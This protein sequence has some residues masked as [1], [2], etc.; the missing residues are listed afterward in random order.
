MQI[1]CEFCGKGFIPERKW[2]RFCTTPCRVRDWN[3]RHPRLTVAKGFHVHI[4][5]DEPA[6]NPATVK[7]K[8]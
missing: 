1:R 2:Q 6:R 4:V 7:E 3:Q 8:V 5:P